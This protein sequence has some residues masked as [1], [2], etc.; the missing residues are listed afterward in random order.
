MADY[1]ISQAFAEIEDEL[2]SSMVRNL[3]HHKAEETK[4]SFKWSQWQVEQ[5]KSLEEY[6][7]KN[8]KLF[9]GRFEKIN[10][11]IE[12]AIQ[13]AYKQG[14]MEQEI[15]ILKAIKN[16]YKPPVK[17]LKSTKTT[18]EFFKLNERKLN[19]LIK[20]TTNDMKKAEQAVLRRANDHYR[21]IIY[22]A[23]VYANAGGTTYEKA[24]DMA[25]RNFLRSGI[26][27]IEYSN[28]ARHTISDYA[29]MA[30]KTAN[31]RAYLRG[32]GTKREEWGIHTVIVNKRGNPCPLCLPWVGK[33]LIDDVYS[34]G[35]PKE[36]E[37]TGYS[38]LSEA[39]AEGFLHPRCQDAFTTYFE[40]VST[41]PEQELVTADEEQTI[42][43][44]NSLKQKQ[45]Y[46]QLMAE[47]CQ[48]IADNSLDE[49]NQKIYKARAIEH[50][51]IA[52]E[53]GEKITDEPVEKSAESG[54]IKSITIDKIKDATSGY[55]IEDEIINAIYSTI[56]EIEDNKTVLFFDV[57]IKNGLVDNLGRT[58]LMQT[59]PEPGGR[60]CI[61][62]LLLNSDLLSGRSLHELDEMLK[63]TTVNICQSFKEA[64][65]HECGHAKMY[66]GKSISIITEICRELKEKG[67]TGISQIALEDGSE[68]IA[69]T[70]V[71]MYRGAEIPKEAMELYNK[72]VGE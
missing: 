51:K 8:Q 46:H 53:T 15:K 57:K 52:D 66:K 17:S 19:A 31:K 63:Q 12:N 64:I 9:A 58:A 70:E 14:G 30:V 41:P 71:L 72:Y 18:G 67:V 26:D 35:T 48:R 42:K 21:K 55:I 2:I 7:A 3:K 68:C 11:K 28:G 22:N 43:E 16:G 27:C 1:D 5:L 44:N 23:Q 34:G 33:I 49:D 10:T 25:T 47:K 40:G 6:K 37:K 60:K 62:N 61:V 69:E 65:I 38:L 50:T 32:E 54:I 29:D 36:A 24:V 13:N 45:Q 4:E 59:S 20:S 56:S 39:M